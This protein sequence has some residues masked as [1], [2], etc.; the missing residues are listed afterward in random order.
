MMR[1]L[2]DVAFL[3]LVCVCADHQDNSAIQ[4]ECKL[5]KREGME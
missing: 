2:S 5:E 4:A 1:M 3:P